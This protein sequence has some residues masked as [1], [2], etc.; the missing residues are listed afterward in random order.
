MNTNLLF[1][2]ARSII[3]QAG[4]QL[5][6]FCRWELE[7]VL[8]D[9]R[10]IKTLDVLSIKLVRD[11]VR[12][13]TDELEIES[14]LPLGDWVYDIYPNRAELY[15]TLYRIPVHPRTGR[16]L[17]NAEIGS[18]TMKAVLI[19]PV[20][21]MLSVGS[22]LPPSKAAMNK[23]RHHR[24]RL[25]LL[26][27]I[28]FDCQGWQYSTITY[29]QNKADLLTN[30]LTL[31]PMVKGV[32]VIEPTAEKTISNLVIPAGISIT[33]LPGWLQ[34]KGGGVY[35]SGIGWYL[36]RGYWWVYPLYD[37]SRYS[38]SD[39][40]TLTII[41]LPQNKM[42]GVETTFADSDGE[43]FIIATGEVKFNDQTDARQLTHGTGV[44]FAKQNLLQDDPL[45][46]TVKLDRRSNLAEVS[47]QSRSDKNHASFSPNLQRE[48]QAVEL[49]KLAEQRGIFVHL[50]WQNS[51]LSIL[52]PGM[53]VRFLFDDGGKVVK[54][55]G[56]LLS[57]EHHS[58]QVQEG[59]QN[60]QHT[61]SS[62][63][64]LF[65]NRSSLGD[66]NG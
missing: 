56:T 24:F 49:S 54:F 25:Q 1:N 38:K 35:N 51:T 14:Y 47:Y 18:Q 44:R 9:G 20:D 60:R 65:L 3:Q 8:P 28:I 22:E 45:E 34:A 52:D 11:F 55:E 36:Q 13:F 29:N 64:S 26:D 21:Y 48:N 19:K 58:M 15:V 41:N 59:V 43:I 27:D 6:A 23:D 42:G 10:I 2:N 12:N 37:T 17:L 66:V 46:E 5:N 32:S 40:K 61:T 31:S 63:L 33:E 30:A 39:S 4:H 50:V 7:F 16:D 53:P 57:V 62:F